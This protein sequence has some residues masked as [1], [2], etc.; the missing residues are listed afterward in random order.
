MHCLASVGNRTPL[1]SS[2]VM[3]LEPL[4]VEK[5]ERMACISRVR[6]GPKD[7]PQ[8]SNFGDHGRFKVPNLQ[9]LENLEVS[10][11]ENLEVSTFENLEVSTLENLDASTFANLEVS[12]FG[13][14]EVSTF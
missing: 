11:F 8:H 6:G 12:T 9:L 5:G 2:R 4:P 3:V 10:T 13:N 1:A 7:L 14:L